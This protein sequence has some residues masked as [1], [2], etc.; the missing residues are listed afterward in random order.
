M[1][2]LEPEMEILELTVDDI[3]TMSNNETSTG[4]SGE[5]GIDTGVGFE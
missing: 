4:N 3:V 5:P 1:K 2:Y